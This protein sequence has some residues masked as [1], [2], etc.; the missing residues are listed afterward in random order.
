MTQAQVWK[1]AWQ[2]ELSCVDVLGNRCTLWVCPS[3][4]VSKLRHISHSPNLAKILPIRDPF[5]IHKPN[6]LLTTDTGAQ[7][8]V[9][10]PMNQ[11]REELPR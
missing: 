4:P 6:S 1:N 7:Q 3:Y 5:S 11:S 10:E 2:L 9:V 8:K